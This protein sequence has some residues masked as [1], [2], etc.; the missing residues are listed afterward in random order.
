M[1]RVSIDRGGGSSIIKDR[2]IPSINI[3][4]VLSLVVRCWLD[5]HLHLLDV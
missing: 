4:A 2:D 5:P 1:N 3:L